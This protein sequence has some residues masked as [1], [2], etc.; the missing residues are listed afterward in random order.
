MIEGKLNVYAYIKLILHTTFKYELSDAPSAFL[1]LDESFNK[2][3]NNLADLLRKTSRYN[4]PYRNPSH[5]RVF[6]RRQTP[7][8]WATGESNTFL[9]SLGY[10]Y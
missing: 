9:I 1:K 4:Y 2:L 8:L 10:L 6:L 7:G 5:V 3:N